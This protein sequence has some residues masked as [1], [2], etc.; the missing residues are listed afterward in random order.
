MKDAEQI[1]STPRFNSATM[2]NCSILFKVHTSIEKE[3]AGCVGCNE[4]KDRYNFS[5]ISVPKE[6]IVHSHSQKVV[7]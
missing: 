4:A 5:P 6:K 2:K 1:C 3:Q 7:K